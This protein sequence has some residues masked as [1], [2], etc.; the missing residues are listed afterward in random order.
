[1]AP[2][3]PQWLGADATNT[4][5]VSSD[6]SQMARWFLSANFS[7]R[8]SNSGHWKDDAFDSA[9]QELETATDPA[10]IQALLRTAHERLVDSAPWLWIVHDLNPRAMSRRVTGFTSAQSWFQDL[11]TVDLR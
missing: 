2:D 11:T 4:S 1:V 10:R 8:G 7:P 3:Q 5:L 6:P 9:F